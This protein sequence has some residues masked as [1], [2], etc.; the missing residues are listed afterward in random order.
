MPVLFDTVS[1]RFVA[2]AETVKVPGMNIHGVKLGSILRNRPADIA[3]VKDGD[4]VIQFDDVPI[5]TNKE[6][7]MRV[8]RALPYTTVKLVVM[9]PQGEPVTEGEAQQLEKVEIPV[10]LGKQ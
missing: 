3:G 7:L 2:A 10:R 4:I 6:F 5:R 9:R 8:R 1:E